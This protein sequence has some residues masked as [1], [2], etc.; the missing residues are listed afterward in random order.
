MVGEFGLLGVSGWCVR[1]LLEV[2]VWWVALVVSVG[3]LRGRCCVLY[4]V[5]RVRAGR[6]D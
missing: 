2:V 1:V 3:G 4:S 6:I 5:S